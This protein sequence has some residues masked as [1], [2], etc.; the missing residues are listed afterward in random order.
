MLFNP[1]YR[2]VGLLALPSLLLF[3]VLG[4]VIELSGYG[5]A[6]AAWLL[7]RLSAETFALFLAV[8]VLY[9]LFLTLGAIALEDATFGRHPGWDDL[10]RVLLFAFGENAGFRQLSHLWRLE[11]FWQLLRKGEWGAMERK[12]FAEP[13][14]AG[15]LDSEVGLR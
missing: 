4:P 6:T 12:G 11:G 5:V 7:G 8:S 14:V 13:E 1:R 9:G 2:A 3:E 15:A 10:G